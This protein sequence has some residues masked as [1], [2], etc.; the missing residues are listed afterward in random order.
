[1]ASSYGKIKNNVD[2]FL[3]ATNDYG[4]R[5]VKERMNFMHEKFY[6]VPARFYELDVYGTVRHMVENGE[7]IMGLSINSSVRDEDDISIFAYAIYDGKIYCS[8]ALSYRVFNDSMKR[9]N[10]SF[11]DCCGFS[12]AKALEFF[13]EYFGCVNDN[14]VDL[15]ELI[16]E[17]ISEDVTE[18]L[19]DI[20]A[21]KI[22]CYDIKSMLMES[23]RE[24][25]MEILE[26]EE[27]KRVDRLMLELDEAK[28]NLDRKKRELDEKHSLSLIHN[29][30]SKMKSELTVMK[31]YFSETVDYHIKIKAIPR[32]M[33][34]NIN[35]A[36]N[37][38]LDKSTSE[39][40]KDRNE[41]GY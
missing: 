28:R 10:K 18:L 20:Y 38:M 16:V 40:K 33:A 32:A 22:E 25:D 9:F 37:K 19:N 6:S 24:M 4:Y 36:F 41:S 7:L 1:M 29:Y 39:I 30:H 15:K 12:S 17:N 31:F 3:K 5:L 2:N 34:N 8:D 26:S 11:K 13:N 21:K 35:A 14:D 23:R 27:K